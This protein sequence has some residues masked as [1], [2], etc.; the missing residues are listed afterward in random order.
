MSAAHS[1]ARSLPITRFYGST[2][3]LWEALLKRT[4]RREVDIFWEHEK[5]FD[6]ALA[7]RFGESVRE[8]EWCV[9]TIHRDVDAF[10]ITV[11]VKHLNEDF[12]QLLRDLL[13]ATLPDEPVY[14]GIYEADVMDY[15]GL[16][17]SF[18][19]FRNELWSWIRDLAQSDA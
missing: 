6:Q 15:Y 14:L 12:L 1:V 16:V 3:E 5:L 19:V 4:K 8:T 13:A 2:E 10:L 7:H 11:S 9:L 17:A 18:A